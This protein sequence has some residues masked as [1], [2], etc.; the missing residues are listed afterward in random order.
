MKRSSLTIG[1][2]QAMI[3]TY[4]LDEGEATTEVGSAAW[5]QWLEQATA[6]RFRDEVGHFTAHKTRAGNQRGRTYW[7]ATRRRHD[8]LASYY[9]GSSDRLTPEHLRQAA[10]AL[11]VRVA[12]DHLKQKTASTLPHDL[13][14]QPVRAVQDSGLAP[15]S[16][17]PKPL[18]R[19][20]GRTSERAKLVDLLRRPEV[21]LLTLT[22][23]GGVGK[24]RLALEAVHDL[25]P[26]F[27]NGV[28]FVPL[29][30]IREP[31]FVLPAIAQ[32]LGVRETSARSP[33]E[34]LQAVLR[35]QSLLLLLDNF[36]QVLAAAPPL[37]DLLAFCRHVKL[38]VTSRAVLRL[39]G[40]HE[41]SRLSPVTARPRA[42][43]HTGIPATVCRLCPLR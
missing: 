18:T 34:D 42:A 15:P 9:L 7:R 12:D 29:A 5:F 28:Y 25:V 8:R 16:P 33:L 2:V 4:Q 30:A 3:L 17:L 26:D 39:Q 1:V 35:D 40:E 21:R 43:T 37:A 20:L 6:F 23:P 10:H 14:A 27:A 41:L 38:L 36:E 11:S 31:D 13:L 19:L 22:G 32:A 24:T